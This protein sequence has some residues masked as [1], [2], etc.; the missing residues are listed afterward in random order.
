MVSECNA[1][2]EP[3]LN[4][5]VVAFAVLGNK[6]ASASVV[7]VISFVKHYTVPPYLTKTRPKRGDRA[8]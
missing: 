3:T 6:D 2:L 4:S 8:H 7:S 5:L 1:P